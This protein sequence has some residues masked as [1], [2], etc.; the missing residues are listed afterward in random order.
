MLPQ[1]CHSKSPSQTGFMDSRAP[2]WAGTSGGPPSDEGR[3]SEPSQ[4][5]SAWESDCGLAGRSVAVA[6]AGLA[7]A[8]GLAAGRDACA[9]AGRVPPPS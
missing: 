2:A 4:S 1:T 5:R 6:M 9:D 7:L 8:Q 3:A